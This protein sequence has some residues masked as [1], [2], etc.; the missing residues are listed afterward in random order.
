MNHMDHS[1]SVALVKLAGI[2]V[3]SLLTS[4]ASSTPDWDA[5]FGDS[6]RT[7]AAQQVINP[8]ASKNTNPVNGL[9]GQAAEHAMER[10]QKSFK[11]PEPQSSVLN[12]GISS[13]GGGGSK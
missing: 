7:S 5:R 2:C 6:V 11:Q 1:N 3:L 4:C 9:D 8:E 13:G 12:I 10:Y